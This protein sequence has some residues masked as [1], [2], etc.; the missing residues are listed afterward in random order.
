MTDIATWLTGH[1][2]ARHVET[3]RA[4]DIDFDVLASLSEDDLKELGLS[5][6]D[7]KRLI[8]AIAQAAEIPSA[9]DVPAPPASSAAPHAERRQL[10]VVFLDLVDSTALSQALDPEDLR[11]VMQGFHR[12]AAETIREA[13]GFVAK[14][15]G[16]GVLAYFGYPHASEDAA[17]RAVRGGLRAIAAI[18]ALPAPRNHV[19]RARVG[20]ATGPV[21]VGDVTGE[22]LARE[23]NVI[24]ETPNLAARL[25]GVG[26][27]DGVI[28]AGSTRRLVGNLY[29]LESLEPQFLK[30]IAEPVLAFRVVSERQGLSRFEATRGTGQGAPFVGR[31]QEVGL[32]LDRW[33]TGTGRR[34][35]ARPDFR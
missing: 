12:A 24:G 35:P 10:T 32:L 19:L 31:A 9:S 33:K 23:V 5:L 13:G 17:E 8:R 14:F 15:M 21:V 16:D 34:R 2:L 25:L 26:P 28:I 20:I 7:R 4:N 30:G 22:D 27:P 6:G 11:D 3:F 1:G 29:V 18:K